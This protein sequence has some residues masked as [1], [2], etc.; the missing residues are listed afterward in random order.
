M[1]S[2]TDEAIQADEVKK[3]KPIMVIL[4]NPPYSG[5]STNT[6]EWITKKIEDYKYVDGVHF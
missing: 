5:I 2:I 6:G 3:D 4:G 1:E